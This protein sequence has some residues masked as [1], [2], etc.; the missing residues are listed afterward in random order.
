MTDSSAGA[1][2]KRLVG[3]RQKIP[4]TD[5]NDWNEEFKAL[6][7]QYDETGAAP[8]GLWK[9]V[10]YR[11]A[12]YAREAE[13]NADRKCAV[14]E[15]PDFEF[16]TAAKL[17]VYF[18]KRPMTTL[19]DDPTANSFAYRFRRLF[20]QIRALHKGMLFRRWAMDKPGRREWLAKR[21]AKQAAKP[22]VKEFI[23]AIS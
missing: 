7:K 2:M 4:Y 16:W 12:K 10:A 18:F 20:F 8:P 15:T 1:L 5:E 19:K 17:I 11:V 9:Q 14:P 6:M 13:R 21:L 3:E 22:L 23:N